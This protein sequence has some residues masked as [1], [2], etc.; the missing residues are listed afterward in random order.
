MHT[1]L[2]SPPLLLFGRASLWHPTYLLTYLPP[3]QGR[4]PAPQNHRSI[5]PFSLP[6][7][8]SLPPPFLPS[9]NHTITIRG[10]S[11]SFTIHNPSMHLFIYSSIYQSINLPSHPI[12][13]DSN[14]NPISCLHAF[15]HSLTHSFTPILALPISHFS[16]LSVCCLPACL[17]VCPSQ[18]HQSPPPLIHP[19]IPTKET[20]SLSPPVEPHYLILLPLSCLRLRLAFPWPLPS[21]SSTIT[22]AARFNAARCENREPPCAMPCVQ[23]SQHQVHKKRSLLDNDDSDNNN[24]ILSL[25]LTH[26][27]FPNNAMSPAPRHIHPNALSTMPILLRLIC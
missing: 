14:P 3:Y 25:K 16:S 20:S 2:R 26:A 18:V 10:K 4:L 19:R 13:S 7:F 22:S 21:F 9:Y 12:P 8:L 1:H 27:H 15:T 6:P 24:K 17:S 11:N 23:C 5:P